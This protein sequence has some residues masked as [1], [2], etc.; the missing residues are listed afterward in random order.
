M[1]LNLALPKGWATLK[2][3]ENCG[4]SL[5]TSYAQIN[6]EKKKTEF[7]CHTTRANGVTYP[8]SGKKGKWPEH[9]KWLWPLGDQ[10]CLLL[11]ERLNLG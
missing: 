2:I 1:G 10:K 6:N 4:N 9:T 5:L 11:S 7:Y 8:F 3:E